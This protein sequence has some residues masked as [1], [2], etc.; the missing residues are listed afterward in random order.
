MALPIN[1][2]DLIHGHSVEWERLEPVIYTDEQRILFL[3]TLP[4]H[5]LLLEQESGEV[6]KHKDTEEYNSFILRTLD[7]IIAYCDGVSNKV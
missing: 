3:T 2:H 1:I 7:D 5:P 4:V 6:S